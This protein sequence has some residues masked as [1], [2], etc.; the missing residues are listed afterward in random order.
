MHGNSL[1]YNCEKV[2]I[3]QLKLC[4][5]FTMYKGVSKYNV[6]V[7]HMKKYGRLVSTTT[8]MEYNQQRRRS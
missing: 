6:N 8:V 7:S 1:P 2:D 3:W 4:D 5:Y